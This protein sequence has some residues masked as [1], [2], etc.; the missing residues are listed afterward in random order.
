[1]TEEELQSIRAAGEA[2]GRRLVAEHP[3]TPA[4][5]ARLIQILRPA[6][7][8]QPTPRAARPARPTRRA[9]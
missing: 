9:S 8:A 6:F 7:D 5:E 3:L 2:N 4:K 1:V